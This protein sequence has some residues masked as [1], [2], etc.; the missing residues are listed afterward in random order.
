M[1]KLMRRLSCVLMAVIFLYGSHAASA[2]TID[3]EDIPYSDLGYGPVHVHQYNDSGFLVDFFDATSWGA[4][5]TPQGGPPGAQSGRVAISSDVNVLPTGSELG[6]FYGDI[7]ITFSQSAS[8][9][10]IYAWTT[11]STDQVQPT[12]SAYD[13]MGQLLGSSSYKFSDANS[14][15]TTLSFSGD[16]IRSIKLTGQNP[17]YVMGSLYSYGFPGIFD[18]LT[19]TPQATPVPI[20]STVWLFISGISGLGVFARRRNA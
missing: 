14:Q 8:F 2:F 15:V 13:S 10:S 6:Q 18:D 9:V 19:I 16:G 3:F 20:S 12:L 17:V 4:T 11:T 7:K 5:Y 1:N